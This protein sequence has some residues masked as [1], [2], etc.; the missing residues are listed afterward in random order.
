[1]GPAL[2][3]PLIILLGMT[4]PASTAAA[5]TDMKHEA[6]LLYDLF[7]RNSYNPLIRPVINT[8]DTLTIYF[9][10]ALS[11]IVTVD[12]VNQ[13]IKT[14]V[15]LQIYWQDYQL[16]WDPGEY[17]GLSSIR[18]PSD[19]VWVPDLVLYNNADGKFEVTYKSNVV[20]Y[21]SSDL[22]WIPPA[23]FQS[24]CFIDVTY[25]PFDQQICTMKFGSWAYR[26]NTLKYQFYLNFD[27]ADLASYLKSGAWDILDA[28][29]EIVTEDDTE[30]IV[31]HFVLRRK[32]LFFI[33][34]LIIPCLLIASLTPFT[35]ILPAEAGEKLTLCISV[36]LAL[37]FFMLMISELLPPA[38][39]VPL[40]AK[41]LVFTFI[42]DLVVIFV[43]VFI[44][45]LSH[46]GPSSHTPMPYWV[47][48]VF[49]KTLPKWLRMERPDY[50]ERWEG[51]SSPI[52]ADPSSDIHPDTLNAAQH[53]DTAQLLDLSEVPPGQPSNK[54]NPLSTSNHDIGASLDQSEVADH[55]PDADMPLSGFKTSTMLTRQETTIGDDS[56]QVH[57]NPDLVDCM[58]NIRMLCATITK[59]DDYN[60]CIDDWKYVGKVIDRVLL[61]VFTVVTFVG[62]TAVLLNSP[63]V[64]DQVDQDVII[65]ELLEYMNHVK[66]EAAG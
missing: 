54:S 3:L 53:D 27:K 6:Q 20:L 65:G 39:S 14:N 29:G 18:V 44:I 48:F 33:V 59:G 55:P 49:L 34:N 66:A 61:V 50:L 11:Q 60:D 2:F 51:P 63:H 12:E 23:I 4:S 7:Q 30:L 28:P 36:L 13:M 10:L 42:N 32:S 41:F 58:N 25:F 19:M 52:V 38:I 57:V 46:R 31:F 1:M 21:S 17:G 16:G 40:L 64:L 37:V 47:R 56:K 9:N 15:W 8:T 5:D 35:F 45:N 26:G 43:T 62:M 24:S 22:N